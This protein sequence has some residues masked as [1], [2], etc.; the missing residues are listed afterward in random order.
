MDK[1]TLHGDGIDLL[2][3]RG[4]D[5]RTMFEAGFDRELNRQTGI[6]KRHSLSAVQAHCRRVGA[7]VDRYDFGIWVRGALV[8]EVVLSDVSPENRSAA[9]RIAIWRRGSRDKGFGT[10]ALRLVL[11][12]AF[13]RLSLNRV[14]LEVY[15]SNPRARRVYEKLGFVAEGVRRQALW[16]DNEPVDAIVM[17]LLAADYRSSRQAAGAGR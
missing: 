5:A 6:H 10:A 2:P 7:A 14:E 4:E 3:I 8:G 13:V 15:A 11:D 17:A 16:W 9:L 1:P 12:F